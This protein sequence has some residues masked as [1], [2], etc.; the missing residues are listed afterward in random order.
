MNKPR[1]KL[2]KR[3]MLT[4]LQDY[5]QFR[6]AMGAPDKEQRFITEMRK[7]TERLSLAHPTIFAWHGSPLHNW[8][9]IIREGLHFKNTDHGRA[10]GHGVYHALDAVT[11]TGYSGMY[12]GGRSSPA[13]GWPNSV[14]R[15][16]S[17]IAL[18][19]IV[20]APAEFISSSPYYVVQH[21]DWI[22][23]RYLFVQCTPTIDGIQQG[24]ESKPE[25]PFQQDPKRI[26][27]GINGNVIEIPAS[28]VKS[29]KAKKEDRKPA[30]P[31]NPGPLK[32]LK[33]LGGFRNPIPIG[34]DGVE[35]EGESSDDEMDPEDLEVLFGV[36][37]EPEPDIAKTPAK[38]KG[39][40]TDF[41]PGSLDFKSLPLMPVPEY[42][43]S[44]TTKRLMNELMS[45]A[46][47]QDAAN[48][49]ELGW[50]IDI[51]KIDNVYQWIVELHSFHTF[52][53]KGKKLPL[54]DE[55]KK[56]GV[57]SVVLEIRFN[58]DFPYTPPYVRVI[59]PR[60]LSLAQ[61]GGGHIVMGGAMCMELL[62]NTGWSS[63]SSM[64]SVLMQIRMAIASEPFARLDMHARMDDYG[65]GEAAEGYIR[66]CH[67]HGWQV[68]P[69]FKEMVY[70]L[71][72]GSLGL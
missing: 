34:G 64:E 56:K 60:F 70:G 8:H 29:H 72:G 59:R 18:N 26:P 53:V 30:A 4:F 6:F 35:D 20:N 47:V 7:T 49:A 19:E 39:P 37:P 5:M 9:M 48:P 25:K 68:P 23:T 67:T 10:F 61:G 36:D 2:P 11:S 51:E 14:L 54:A 31:K 32:K 24:Q 63:V 27:R 15:I 71:S 38:P 57:K 65:T 40:T 46:K 43:T 12:G 69:G 33:S 13:S 1:A 22:Q 62:T 3:T 50:Y 58:K 28:A 41:V 52:E 17:A 66:A 44:G 45:L 16:G 55:M 42:A 21:L